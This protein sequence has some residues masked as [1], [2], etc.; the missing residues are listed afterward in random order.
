LPN[1]AGAVVRANSSSVQSALSNYLAANSNPAFSGIVLSTV[2]RRPLNVT[3]PPHTHTHARTTHTLTRR[4]HISLARRTGAGAE[5][6]PL[7]TFGSFFFRSKTMEDCNK[8]AALASFLYYSQTDPEAKSIADRYTIPASAPCQLLNT[9][10][11][12]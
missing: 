3:P 9:C 4:I 7:A 6:W 12:N 1:A 11:P 8:A 2:S 10:A 5:S